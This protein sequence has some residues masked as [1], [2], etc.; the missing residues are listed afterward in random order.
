MLH[1]DI[2]FLDSIAGKVSLLFV[3]KETA[4]MH[5]FLSLSLDQDVFTRSDQHV[6]TRAPTVTLFVGNGLYIGPLTNPI[7]GFAIWIDVM[8]LFLLWEF[9]YG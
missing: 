9:V 7:L 6:S 8:C 3:E 5:S 4:S 2:L 1:S